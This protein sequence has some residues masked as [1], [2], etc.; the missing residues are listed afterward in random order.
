LRNKKINRTYTIR[1]LL[2]LA[3]IISITGSQELFDIN[4][5]STN[6][7][8]KV[9]LKDIKKNRLSDD[10][11]KNNA[12]I[13]PHQ[14]IL[15]LTGG[16]LLP[17][18]DLK[19]DVSK[20]NF[21]NSATTALSYYENW[22]YTFGILSKLST[23]K[24]DRFRVTVSLSLNYF[25]NT[26]QDS[27][28]LYTVEPELNFFQAGLGAEWAFL[29]YGQQVVYIG[30]DINA[31]SHSGSINIFNDS[32]G[33]QISLLYSPVMRFGA[34]VNLGVDYFI[35]KSFG[36]TGGLKYSIT[37]LFG[38]NYDASGL[39]DLNDDSYTLNGFSINKKTISYLGI[40]VGLSVY[41]GD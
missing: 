32:T 5:E 12:Y 31:S 9:R 28:G 1:I 40:Y 34:S 24:M 33:S 21:K 16:Y 20:I 18:A 4:F 15:S 19:G 17:T 23:D 29:N 14:L 7:I 36:L 13:K 22:G 30:F 37:N 35:S 3:F 6:L 38:K 10:D 2:L 8:S 39:H 27:S 11:R 25:R 26:G 41:I